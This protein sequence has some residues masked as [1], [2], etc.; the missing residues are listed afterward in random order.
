MNETISR[1]NTL[2][3]RKYLQ[4]EP[5]NQYF[6][7][8]GLGKDL[9]KPGKIAEEL[10]GMLNADGGLLVLGISDKGELQDLNSLASD[11]LNEYRKLVFDFITPPCNIVLEEIML[12]GNLIFLYHVEQE[13]ERTFCHSGSKDYFLRVADTNR[14]LNFE[15]VKK[16]EYDKNIRQFEDEV[17]SDFDEEDLD[18][19]LLE[20]YAKKLNKA[21]CYELLKA[22]HLIKKKDGRILFK[23]SAILLFGKNPESY[24]PTASVRYI[25]YNGVDEKTGDLHN[26]SKDQRFENNIPNL[27]IELRDFLR[28]ALNDYYFLDIKVG[29][30]VKIAEYP[31]YAWLEG[32][33]NALCHRSYNRQGSSIYIK[34]FD[35]RLEISNSG[36]LPAQVTVENIRTERFARNPRIARVLEDFGYVRQLNEGV[37]RIYETMEQSM[38]SVPEYSVRNSNVYLILRNRIRAHSKTIHTAVMKKIEEHWK[39]YN[40]TQANILLYLFTQG[41]ATLGQIEEKIQINKNTI[42]NYLNDFIAQHILEKRSEKKTRCQRVVWL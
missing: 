30:F 12:D 10:I 24:I 4:T 41:S 1:H 32:I 38:L 7:R 3:T 37:K 36:P 18:R 40:E 2:I 9:I 31:E 39:E 5:E 15:Q 25:R 33:V 17:V 22:R 8:K 14:K 29:R 35:D 34:H 19:E 21:D 42:R 11:T 27:I 26:V 20:E 23:K 13:F 28:I 16:L 6:E